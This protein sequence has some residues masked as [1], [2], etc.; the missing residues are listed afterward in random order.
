MIFNEEFFCLSNV[1]QIA[2]DFMQAKHFIV[3]LSNITQ[4]A[5]LGE[6]SV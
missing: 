3:F 5:E 2:M 6:M 1:L 4:I